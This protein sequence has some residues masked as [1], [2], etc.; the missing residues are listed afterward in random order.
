MSREKRNTCNARGRLRK[1]EIDPGPGLRG[2]RLGCAL[3][4][5]LAKNMKAAH[6][7]KRDGWSRVEMMFVHFG[8]AQKTPGGNGY[9]RPFLQVSRPSNP[10]ISPSKDLLVTQPL[11]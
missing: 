11:T 10:N 5:L 1:D 7:E 6:N 2:L 9:F 3:R 4:S 8:G